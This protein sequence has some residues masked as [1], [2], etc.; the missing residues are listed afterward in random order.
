M[1]ERGSSIFSKVTWDKFSPIGKYVAELIKSYYDTDTGATK[2]DRAVLSERAKEKFSN[3]KQSEAVRVYVDSL[4]DD[5]SIPNLLQD[6]T[7]FKQQAIGDELAMAIANKSDKREIFDLITKYQD[8]GLEV[9]DDDEKVYNSFSVEKLVTK[10]FASDNLVKLLPK[11]LN[12]RC[13]GGAR[14]GHHILVYARPEIGKTLFVINLTAGF[15]VQNLKVLYVGNEDPAT[16]LLIR[17]VARLSKMSKQQILEEPAKAE[18]RAK[19]KGYDN[20]VIASLS[21]GNFFDIRKLVEQHKPNVVILDQLR[22]IDVK[23]DSRVQGLEKAAT[24]AR[25]LGKKYGVVVVSVT[26]AGESA[27]GKAVLGRDDI[28]FS[29]TGIPAQVDLMIGIGADMSM[30]KHG[31]R[32][33]SLPK[34]KLSGN[35]DYFSISINPSIGTVETI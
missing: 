18:E 5:I 2:V 30:E 27:E 22:N 29:K 28:D 23:S 7:D 9:S 19:A 8:A 21:P 13:D 6:I 33:V 25:N 15:L 14:P 34:N 10:S 35:H 3:P 12:D 26:Q 1:V 24:E 20:L 4:D 16:D 32:T 31:I 11:A 17:V